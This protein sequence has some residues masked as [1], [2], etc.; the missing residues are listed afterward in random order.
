[1]EQSG[2][3]GGFFCFLINVTVNYENSDL[4]C[5]TCCDEGGSYGGASPVRVGG[6][7]KRCSAGDM[8]ASHGSS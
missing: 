6:L 3:D 8:G 1:M 4:H 7:K 5:H 2:T